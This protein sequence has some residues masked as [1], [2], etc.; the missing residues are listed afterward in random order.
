[1]N[2]LVN[3]LILFMS[4]GLKAHSLHDRGMAYVFDNVSPGLYGTTL[5]KGFKLSDEPSRLNH[6]PTLHGFHVSIPLIAL[7]WK[8]LWIIQTEVLARRR[9]PL[10]SWLAKMPPSSLQALYS[11][12]VR[13]QFYQSRNVV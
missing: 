10:S 13:S 5:P 3:A 4:L 6:Q 11:T 2:R 8:F 12:P 7:D 1:M 9:L